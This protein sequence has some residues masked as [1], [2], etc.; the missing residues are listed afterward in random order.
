MTM[1]RYHSG[2]RLTA[3]VG[4]VVTVARRGR[5][6]VAI[7]R[8]CSLAG[9]SVDPPQ[10]EDVR[11]AVPRVEAG[12][13]VPAVPPGGDPGEQVVGVDRRGVVE[14]EGDEVDVD[15]PGPGVDVV[16]VDHDEYR[17]VGQLIVAVGGRPRRRRLAVD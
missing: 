2:G 3:E 7:V 15:H 11:R 5:L 16:R 8:L 14:L 4:M 10:R 6:E 17:I 9:R 13:L 1:S 12:V